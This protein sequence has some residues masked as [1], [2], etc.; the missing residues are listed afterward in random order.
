MRTIAYAFAAA[1]CLTVGP[2]VASSADTTAPVTLAQVDLNVG[3]GAGDHRARE[4]VEIRGDRDR[5]HVRGNIEI[6]GGERAYNRERIIVR[7][8]A[9]CRATVVRTHRPNGTVV[10][11]RI[12]TCR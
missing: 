12:Q 11:R 4:G 1:A 2:V 5:D 6:R 9:P 7:H 8:R 3:V 10:I